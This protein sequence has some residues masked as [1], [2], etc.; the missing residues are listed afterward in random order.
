MPNLR[1]RAG[2]LGQALNNQKRRLR[3]QG[4]FVQYEVVTMTEEFA[5][6]CDMADVRL[7]DDLEMRGDLVLRK[8]IILYVVGLVL[9]IEKRRRNDQPVF[10]QRLFLSCTLAA[11]ERCFTQVIL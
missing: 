1:E 4:A 6:A 8:F 3:L 7:G 2:D 9:V 11:L 5:V 10:A